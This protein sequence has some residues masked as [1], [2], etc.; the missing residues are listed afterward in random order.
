[1]SRSIFLVLPL[2]FLLLFTGG[3]GKAI[4][5]VFPETLPQQHVSEKNFTLGVEQRVNVGEAVVSVK[6]Y[7]NNVTKT[8]EF[9]PD[10]DF[11]IGLAEN[12]ALKGVKGLPIKSV[13][14]LSDKD[15]LYYLLPTVNYQF[16]IPIHSSGVY[17]GGNA[18]RIVGG[19]HSGAEAFLRGKGDVPIVPS[20]THFEREVKEVVDKSKQYVN[21]EI[22]YTGISKDSINFL[23]REYT[24][25]D[26]ARAAFYQNLTYPTDAEF[27][28]FKSVRVEIAKV[29]EQGITYRVTSQ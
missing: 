24:I 6:E 2:L 19:F 21:Y 16:L 9:V 7:T 12:P 29:D 18:V 20:E 25:D 22:V 10:R 15:G 4:M 1:M 27:I 17:Q 11:Y 13:G 5:P 23:Y 8:V 28:Q 3:C 14:T 26:L